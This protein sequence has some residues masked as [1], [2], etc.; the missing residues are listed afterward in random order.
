MWILEL[1]ITMIAT[2]SW[3]TEGAATQST[4]P[5]PP[6]SATA[7][8]QTASDPP[9]PNP[10]ECTPAA[11]PGSSTN[12][13]SASVCPRSTGRLTTNRRSNRD[14]AFTRRFNR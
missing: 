5:P 2:V 12:T 11:T 10:P 13:T 9:R 7:A 3:S 6:I 4:V 14:A 1:S 8:G